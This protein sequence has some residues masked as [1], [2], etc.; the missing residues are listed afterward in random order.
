MAD[1]KRV[2]KMQENDERLLGP[3]SAD[4]IPINLQIDQRYIE[5]V[6]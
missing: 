3:R 4:G 2:Q 5:N 1:A 6:F